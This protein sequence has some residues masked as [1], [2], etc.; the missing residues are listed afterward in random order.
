MND[1]KMKAPFLQTPTASSTLGGQA[2]PDFQGNSVLAHPKSCSH[3][4]LTATPALQA[5]NNTQHC[6]ALF[7]ST[8]TPGDV[9]L[10]TL[11]GAEISAW[12]TGTLPQPGSAQLDLTGQDFGLPPCHHLSTSLSQTGL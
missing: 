10:L 1:S 3:I 2:A 5:L 7:Q 4:Q 12:G 9:L 6:P 8:Q 11:G